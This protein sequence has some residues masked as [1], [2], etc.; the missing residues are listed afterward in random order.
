MAGGLVGFAYKERNATVTFTNCENTSNDITGRKGYIGQI[1][2]F[3]NGYK[4]KF[5]NCKGIENKDLIGSE[6]QNQVL[7][8]A[9]N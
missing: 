3:A 5:D 1:I 8:N 9:A 4:V 7:E 2:V 6:A